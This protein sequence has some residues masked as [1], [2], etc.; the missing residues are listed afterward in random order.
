MPAELHVRHAY[1]G[2]PV[3]EDGEHQYRYRLTREWPARLAEK[4]AGRVLFVGLNPS[5]ADGKSDDPTLRRMIRFA[6][7]W[8]HSGLMVC[9]LFAHRAT[10]PR[11]LREVRD[12]VGPE[13]EQ[14]L[15][16]GA[17]AAQRIVACWGSDWMA[18]MWPGFSNHEYADWARRVYWLLSEY[19]TVECLGRTRSG[20]PRHPVR[21]AAATPLEPLGWRPKPEHEPFCTCGHSWREHEP[22]RAG[23]MRM[24]QGLPIEINELKRCHGVIRPDAKY[25]PGE[26]TRNLR[27][28]CEFMREPVEEDFTDEPPYRALRDT[29]VEVAMR[30]PDLRPA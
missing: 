21:L 5:T 24:K 28:R 29:A 25:V 23:R 7:D 26:P 13:N 12:P 19:R 6:Q 30:Q 4:R 2:G 18:R 10:D 15:R 9:N 1:F 11:E 14:S 17:D 27:C 22:T 3:N 8:G 16:E 20:H